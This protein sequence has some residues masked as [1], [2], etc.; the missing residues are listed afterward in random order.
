MYIYKEFSWELRVNQPPSLHNPWVPFSLHFPSRGNERKVSS[1]H[2]FVVKRR[3]RRMKA[4]VQRYVG[5]SVGCVHICG[6][7]PATQQ[8]TSSRNT[9]KSKAK[10]EKYKYD[11]H[12]SLFARLDIKTP[13]PLSEKQK[14]SNNLSH[15]KT[16]FWYFQVFFFIKCTFVLLFMIKSILVI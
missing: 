8:I 11:G 1:T 9:S 15:P 6:V 12:P 4:D 13:P 5:R 3:K 2:A 16:M 10:N 14:S 7:L